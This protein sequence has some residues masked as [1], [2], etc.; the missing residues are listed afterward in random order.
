MYLFTRSGRLAPGSVRDGMSHVMAITD[1]VNQ[2]TGL[3]VHT[4]SA[5]M[6]PN[7]GTIVWAA[8]VESLDELEA[9]QDKLAV[10]EQFI[11]LAEQGSKLFLG[12]LT[13]GLAS[14]VVGTFDRS[15][16]LPAYAAVT[17]ATAAN[18]KLRRAVAAGIEIAEAATRITGIETS[19]MVDATGAYGGCRWTSGYPDIS[20]VARA[21]EALMADESWTNLVDRVATDYI[22][23]TTQSL[24]RRII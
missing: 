5:S 12:P 2:E 4:W 14:V 9:A 10:S 7:Q 20:S 3:D 13:D 21:E 8:F 16:P 22:E 24:Y 18:G 23:G 11:D 17:R 19:F 15:A 6:S 1:K